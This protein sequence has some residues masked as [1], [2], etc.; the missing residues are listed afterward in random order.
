M[1]TG[2]LLS[3]ALF[4]QGRGEITLSKRIEHFN[5]KFIAK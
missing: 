3:L 5:L 1:L 4:R 2:S